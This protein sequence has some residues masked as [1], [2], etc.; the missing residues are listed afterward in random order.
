MHLPR[1]LSFL[2]SAVLTIGVLP[3]VVQQG[4]DAAPA[5]RPFTAL[6]G[7]HPTGDRVR[8]E[9]R[10]YAASRV[11][12]DALRTVL[13]P[14]TATQPVTLAIPGPDGKTV[15]FRVER[16]SLMQSKLA[17]A[18]PE[19]VTFAGRGV[20]DQAATIAMD[21]TPM[22]F[23]ASVRAGGGSR[24]WYVDPAYNERGTTEHLSYYGAALPPAEQRQAEAEV[25]A[26]RSTVEA[27]LSA[28]H[29]AGELVKRRF[30]RLALTSDPSYATYFGTGNVLAEKVTLINRVNQVYNDD[31]ATNLRLVNATDAAQPRHR[32]QGDRCRRPLRRV[33]LLHRWPARR[34]RWRDTGS[35]PDGAR[36]ARR[37]VQLRHRPHRP[38]GQRR[39]RRLS[40]RGRRRLQGRW[41]HGPAP[42]EG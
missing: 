11:D 19:I 30:Y 17:A 20:D 37:R 9:P 23:H 22:G 18:H 5:A 35:Q 24:A 36:A 4:A 10:S 15:R 40:G 26:I 6:S 42:A 2:V 31:L 1:R 16:T 14:A 38:R 33:G 41:L 8:V 13:A 28:Q 25:R 27:K 32:G 3:A 12:V 34:L 7:F 29:L 39:R 21:L